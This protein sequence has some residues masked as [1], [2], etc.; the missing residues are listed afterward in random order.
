[1]LAELDDAGAR[2]TANPHWRTTTGNVGEVRIAF[3]DRTT[4]PPLDEWIA[5][6][7]DLQLVRE[8]PIAARDT[9]SERTP[10]LSTTFL[11]FNVRTQPM[12]DERV[13]QALAH[14]ID[15]MALVAESPG[16]DLA[17]GSG[18]AIPPVIPGHSDGA[19]LPYD[20]ERA[21]ALLAEAGFRGGRGL[22][23][24]VVDARPWSPTS[25]L[26]EQFA[27][28][29]VRVRFESR[30]KHF[31]VSQETHAWFA[32]W[33]ADYP[34]PDGFYLGLL[35]LGLPLYRDDET[36]AVLARAR[37]SRD[38]DERLRLYREFERTWIGQRAALVPLSYAR[39]LVL[40][41]PYVEGLRLNPMGAFHLE[42]V[43]VQPLD[44]PA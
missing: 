39:Q 24:L 43:V 40:R 6:R 27:A 19:G 17:A 5:G 2:L 18:G 8:A 12:A 33:H 10:T 7:Y 36:D 9:V 31:G 32:G 26:A 11:G 4:E 34:D 38:R 1:M 42:Q 29:G 30:G 44:R 41:R 3:R 16:V 25:A 37:M 22:P 21:R 14:A 15:S 23:E 20:P 35:E 13:R 28:I